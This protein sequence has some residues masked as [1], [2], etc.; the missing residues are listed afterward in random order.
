MY[1]SSIVDKAF[2]FP[3]QEQE[4]LY[5]IKRYVKI[6]KDI[7]I[8]PVIDYSFGGMFAGSQ[9]HRMNDMTTHALIWFKEN[10]DKIFD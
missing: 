4:A 5:V 1:L 8:N 10:K 2:A 7:D 9:L 3:L 6:R